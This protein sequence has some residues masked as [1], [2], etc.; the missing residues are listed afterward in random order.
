MHNIIKIS[1]FFAGK[2]F[3][4][5][6]TK[7]GSNSLMSADA[8]IYVRCLENNFWYW[9]KMNVSNFLLFLKYVF[10]SSFVQS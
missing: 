1:L 10:W 4:V 2:L 5:P 7:Y 3:N 6:E 9:F 8:Q